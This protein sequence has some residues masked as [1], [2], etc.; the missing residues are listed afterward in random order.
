M[1]S[2]VALGVVV[3]ALVLGGGSP[4]R[5]A[6]D[7]GPT[8]GDFTDENGVFDLEGY[9]AALLA[10]E[11]SPILPI[12]APIT[13]A[14]NGCPAGSQLTAEF[15]GYPSS[16]TSVVSRGNPTNLVITPP[17][18][19]DVGFNIIRV[20]CATATSLSS[21]A[22]LSSVLFVRDIV[23]DLRPSGTPGIQSSL[24]VSLTGSTGSGGSGGNDLPGAGADSLTIL[25]LGAATVLLGGAIAIGARRRLHQA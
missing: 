25:G 12:D 24:T 14:I 8:A 5:A 1:R 15:V 20:T 17:A 10:F 23:V 2:A 6:R 16:I 7:D 3:A 13:L 11:T 19:I 18:G 4:A 9:T 22:P 21:R